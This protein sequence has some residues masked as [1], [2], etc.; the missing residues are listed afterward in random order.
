MLS[1]LMISGEKERDQTES[2]K[3]PYT[4]RKFKVDNTKH[5]QKIRL[6]N[7]YGPR[8]LIREVTSIKMYRSETEVPRDI[9]NEKKK[10]LGEIGLNIT[11]NA[12]PK[13]GQDQVSGG[14]S[15]LYWYITPVANVLWKPR[16]IR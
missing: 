14:V 7:D 13:V 16:A 10:S 3:N 1:N 12:C 6:H 9:R 15:V 5:Q 8:L 4:S 2:Y 11:T